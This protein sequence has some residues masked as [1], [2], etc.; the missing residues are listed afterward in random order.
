VNGFSF[1]FN[2]LN[3]KQFFVI[4]AQYL[5]LASFELP[6]FIGN[7][8][9]ERW[10]YLANEPYLWPGFFLWY[11]GLFQVLLSFVAFFD[12]KNTN[13]QWNNLR[14]VLVLNF[15]F[16]FGALTLTQKTP[17][18]N[19]YFEMLPIPLLFSFYLWERS[20][21]F[22]WGKP[23]LWFSLVMALVFSVG[24]P[25]DPVPKNESVYMKFHDQFTAAVEKKDYH[26]LGERR[27]G[28]F[29]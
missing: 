14:W 23:F 5:S 20:L 9:V 3:A 6:R 7:H 25:F 17:E 19:T 18:P 16:V 15:A 4:L 21:S 8:T 26:Q 10:H 2:P 24:Y 11:F 29:Y 13:P 27:P 28:A 1:G 12:K 22:S